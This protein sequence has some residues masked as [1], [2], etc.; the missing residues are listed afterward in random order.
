MSTTIKQ[1]TTP[2]D[3]PTTADTWPAHID[4]AVLEAALDALGA[5][6]ADFDHNADEFHSPAPRYRAV[7]STARAYADLAVTLA[8]AYEASTVPDSHEAQ[9]CLDHLKDIEQE[10]VNVAQER[11]TRPPEPTH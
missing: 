6:I 2:H 4:V 8:V 10:P 5:H 7:G 11:A 1:T 3:Q 9:Q